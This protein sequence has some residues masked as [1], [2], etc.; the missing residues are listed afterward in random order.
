MKN[1]KRYV[2]GIDPSG[3][4]NE[5]KGHTGF[6]VFDRQTNTIKET[7]TLA[8]KD[9]ASAEQYF[10]AHW[11][12]IMQAFQQYNG[13]VDCSNGL[14]EKYHE[15][16]VVSIEDFILYQASAKDLI[17]SQ[18]ETPQLLGYLKMMFYEHS[19][20]W[21]IRPA[22]RVKKRWHE[23]ILEHEGYIQKYK[24][25]SY[26]LEHGDH[27]LATHE[28]DAIKHAVH[29]GLFEVEDEYVPDRT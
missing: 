10:Q 4:F 11:V 23:T 20:T 1:Y 16:M 13:W 15:S 17:N 8:A 25:K 12:A 29:C 19:I 21:Y 7:W 28:L 18:L 9:F 27:A 22:V 26:K 6:A 14:G 24:T 5:G 2:L 3:N